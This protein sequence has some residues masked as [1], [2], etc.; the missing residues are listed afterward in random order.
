MFLQKDFWGCLDSNWTL[1][2][3]QN[4]GGRNRVFLNGIIPWNL[5]LKIVIQQREKQQPT[6]DWFRWMR[7]YRF[8]R[9][10]TAW[11]LKRIHPGVATKKTPYYYIRK[12]P[13]SSNHRGV[14]WNKTWLK[15]K[16]L[17]TICLQKRWDKIWSLNH[18]L[19]ITPP[20]PKGKKTSET[21]Q[22]LVGTGLTHLI[23]SPRQSWCKCPKSLSFH[24]RSAGPKESN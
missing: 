14:V 16:K 19:W 1:V 7:I 13:G 2:C 21:F 18:R 11:N 10:S 12:S 3:V 23:I 8:Q 24:H 4:C 9:N 15:K 5:C 17:R 22:Q 6:I 20:G